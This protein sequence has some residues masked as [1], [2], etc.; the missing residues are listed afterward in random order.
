MAIV[1]GSDGLTELQHMAA[2]ELAEAFAGLQ[3]RRVG[4]KE[5]RLEADV[6]GGKASIHPDQ[7]EV[8]WEAGRFAGEHYDFATPAELVAAFV[9]AARGNGAP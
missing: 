3:L 9:Q 4:G 8:I 1:P 2:T 5:L 7:A 6:P